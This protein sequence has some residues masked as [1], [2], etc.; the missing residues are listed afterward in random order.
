MA[1]CSLGSLS[2]ILMAL[3]YFSLFRDCWMSELSWGQTYFS[4]SVSLSIHRAIQIDDW[5]DRES[6]GRLYVLD[7]AEGDFRPV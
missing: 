3:S 7:E 2:P 1:A 4:F 6:E 5:R